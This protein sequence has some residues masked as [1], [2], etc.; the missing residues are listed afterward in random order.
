[1]LLVS[2]D[3]RGRESSVRELTQWLPP[4]ERKWATGLSA[5]DDEQERLVEMDEQLTEFVDYHATEM[6]SLDVEPSQDFDGDEEACDLADQSSQYMQSCSWEDV[7]DVNEIQEDAS[8]VF[9][10]VIYAPQRT[11][12]PNGSSSTS[13]SCRPHERRAFTCPSYLAKAKAIPEE[14]KVVDRRS[15]D[16]KGSLSDACCAG[17][18]TFTKATSGFPTSG[19]ASVGGP[20]WQDGSDDATT[21]VRLSGSGTRPV[22]ASEPQWEQRRSVK[23]DCS[24]LDNSRSCSVNGRQLLTTATATSATMDE[25]CGGRVIE[26]K[27]GCFDSSEGFQGGGAEAPRS[28]SSFQTDAIPAASSSLPGGTSWS[29]GFQPRLPRKRRRADQLTLDRFFQPRPSSTK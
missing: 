6:E 16:G 9:D 2:R 21:A 28:H 15:G 17:D 20:S 8:E 5:R 18:A 26:L 3:A 10:D 4:N 1:M 19:V 11:P 22:V 13:M 27:D 24:F 14:D 29:M 23:R 7:T 12:V 25:S